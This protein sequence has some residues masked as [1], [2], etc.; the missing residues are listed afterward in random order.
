VFDYYLHLC[1]SILEPKLNL[2]CFQTKPFAKFK[3][4][5]FIR[6]RTLFKHPRKTKR[7]TKNQSNPTNILTKLC[8]KKVIIFCD[9]VSYDIYDSSS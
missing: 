8:K 3:P 6:M 1:S 4:L 9:E 5:F 2:S 7:Q